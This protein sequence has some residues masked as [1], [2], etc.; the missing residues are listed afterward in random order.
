M[1]VSA[2]LDTFFLPHTLCLRPLT[3][4]KRYM[5]KP[6]ADVQGHLLKELM[7]AWKRSNAFQNGCRMHYSDRL[8][9][10]AD[11]SKY[12]NLMVRDC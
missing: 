9:L 3:A 1:L 2:H 4:R 11:W 10:A 7:D 5:L 8:R 6:G 12:P